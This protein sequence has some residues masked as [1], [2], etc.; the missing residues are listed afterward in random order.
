MKASAKASPSVCLLGPINVDITL[1]VDEYPSEGGD[2]LCDSYSIETGGVVANTAIVLAKL[3]AKA[4]LIGCMGDDIWSEMVSDAFD[5]TGVDVSGIS[6]IPG[7]ATG[8]NIAIVT[9][10]GERTFFNAWGANNWV[11]PDKLPL[12]LIARADMLQVTGHPVTRESNRSVLL[13]AIDIARLTNVPVSMDTSLRPVMEQTSEILS[14]IPQL[15]ICVV[16]YEEGRHLTDEQDPYAIARNIIS[17]GSNLVAVKL[18]GGGC[19]VA[20]AEEHTILTTHDVT[21]LD[22]TGA[23]DPL[24]AGIIFGWLSQMSIGATAMLANLLGALATTVWGAGT[25]LPGADNVITHLSSMDYHD[26]SEYDAHEVTVMLKASQRLHG[27]NP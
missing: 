26:R 4:Q 7:L 17:R 12:D 19:V 16:G 3:G 21:T 14:L 22:P 8:L 11:E 18:G 13:D 1:P 27:S 23:G 10:S 9:P 5:V 24:T 2:G 6:T 20:T 25:K 15:E